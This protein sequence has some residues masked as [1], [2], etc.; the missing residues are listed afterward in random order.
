MIETPT[1]QFST[2]RGRAY[3]SSGS[4]VRTMHPGNLLLESIISI[5]I[6]AIFL[7]GI[8]VA[9]LSGHRSTIA[10]GDRTRAGYMAQQQIEAVR[11]M[12]TTDF[13]SVT[14]G[15][16]GLKLNPTG[17]AFTGSS[18]VT[19]GYKT[20]V[21]VEL[22][23]TDLLGIQ[24]IVQWNFGNTRSGTVV[25]DSYLSNWRKAST[26]G[27]WSAMTRVANVTLSGTP[28]FQKIAVDGNYAYI[29]SLQSGGGKGL[30]IYDVSNPA[31]PFRVASTFDLGASAYGVTAINNRLYIVTNA[32]TAEL[33]V[34]DISSPTTLVAGNMINSYD[35]PGNGL[36]RSLAVYNTN[37]FVGTIEDATENEFYSIAMSE[38]GP[39]TLQD[40]LSMSG[41]LMAL[42]LSDGY[43]YT[44]TT[45]NAGELQVLD[46]FDPT[47][48]GFAPNVG[49]DMPDVHDA[50]TIVATGTSALIGRVGGSTIDELT[51]YDIGSSPVPTPPPSPWTLETGGDINGLAVAPGS[52]YAFIAGSSSSA[53][54]MVISTKNMVQYVSPV[55]KK[56]YSA[57][58]TMLSLS[59][60]WITDRL[61]VISSTGLMVFAPG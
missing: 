52:E 28:N 25:L 38:T 12:R 11:Q 47:D 19:N 37:I 14:V 40:S 16:H 41:S 34:Y 30:Y 10:S 49:L 7:G 23:S 29:T 43:A 5:G 18:I 57:G 59:Y 4:V 35:I 3:L 60:D 17:W 32:S 6:F 58:T 31:N 27:N 42:S 53:Q 54:V 51:L 24:S 13:A 56:S 44:A 48:I 2:R 39:M 15:T 20:S 26:V 33:Q 21:V 46:I 8:G 50:N 9:L 22:L 36:A 55:M 45:N 61:Y 1:P